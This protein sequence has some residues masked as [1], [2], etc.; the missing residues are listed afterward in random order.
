MPISWAE[1]T[2]EQVKCHLSVIHLVLHRPTPTTQCLICRTCGYALSTRANGVSQH[3]KNLH[4]TPIQFRA[5]VNA[6]LRS[7]G[8]VQPEDIPNCTDSSL[9]Q[10]FLRQIKGTGCRHCHY[11]S[12]SVPLVVSHVRKAHGLLHRPEEWLQDHVQSGL[13]LQTWTANATSGYWRVILQSESESL[14][15]STPERGAIKL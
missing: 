5:N 10:P 7:L 15:P 14:H 3:L 2:P 11:C 12:A 13:T 6:Y 4:Q 8:L 9:P 1:L